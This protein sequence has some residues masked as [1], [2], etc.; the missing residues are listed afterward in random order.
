M[1]GS[2]LGAVSALVERVPLDDRVPESERVGLLVEV[3]GAMS[4]AESVA[5]RI[6]D[7]SPDESTLADSLY[8]R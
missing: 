6:D 3:E 1:T 2:Y 8:A 7:G 5:R 4:A